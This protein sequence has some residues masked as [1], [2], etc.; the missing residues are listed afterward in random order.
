MAAAKALIAAA[1]PATLENGGSI[2]I[3]GEIFAIDKEDVIVHTSVLE[4]L[5]CATDAG[6][7]VALDTRITPALEREGLARDFNRLV[8]DLRKARDFVV[9]QRIALRYAAPDDI[10]AALEE[11]ADT[12]KT[13]LLCTAFERVDTLDAGEACELRGETIRLDVTPA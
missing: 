4:H 8:Q 2:E 13:S 12:L 11:H 7:M 10:A 3:D 6:T 5:V 1:D 9:T